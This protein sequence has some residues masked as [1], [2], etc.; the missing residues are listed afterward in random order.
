RRSATPSPLNF[1]PKIA[2]FGIAALDEIQFPGAEP[3]LDLLFAHDGGQHRIVLL[4]VNEPV[5][6][7]SLREARHD[8]VSMLPDP[9]D[10]VGRDADVQRA[11]SVTCE[12]VNRGSF[13]VH[14]S[15]SPS[16]SARSIT[17]PDG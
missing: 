6:A 5:H 13:L 15:P 9:G 16:F 10:E 17:L 1:K 11:L 4:V 7:M 3:A 8:L 12:H 2:P 14:E